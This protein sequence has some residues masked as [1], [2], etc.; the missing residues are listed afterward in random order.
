MNKWLTR[1][2]L[3]VIAVVLV[4]MPIRSHI[5][6]TD[7]VPGSFL[8]LGD[9]R[10][11][12]PE[13]TCDD[14]PC[15]GHEGAWSPTVRDRAIE[16]EVAR[17]LDHL[18]SKGQ[19]TM[20]RSLK[21]MGRYEDYIDAALAARHL[22]SSLRYLPLVEA[23]YDHLAVSPAGAAGLWQ[24]MPATAR[25]LGLEVNTLVDQRFDE[26]AA[27][28]AALDYLAALQSRFQSWLLALAAYNAGPTRLEGAIR[29]HGEGRS[30][31]DGLFWHI[32]D[33]LPEETRD[34][35]PKFLAS[36]RLAGH[37]AAV[38]Q[39]A[40]RDPPERF[41][42][43]WIEGAASA[44]VL[45]GAA[46][47]A[48]DEFMT[49]NPH[50]RIGLTP[51]DGSTRLRVP[52]GADEMFLVHFARIPVGGRSTLREHTVAPGETLTRI[53]QWHG[54]SLDALRTVNPDVEPRRMQV[55]TVLVI[56]RGAGS[57]V[58]GYRIEA[59]PSANLSYTRIAGI[60]P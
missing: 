43:V 34:F 31:D 5:P 13:P 55:G 32:R 4:M 7:S 44:D 30:L 52:F 29:R 56:P 14:R 21:R 47:I 36:V 59:A 23:G 57:S 22:P 39:A 17:W 45:A 12:R 40:E 20:R 50:L 9:D 26:H 3:A 1:S 11:A 54:V 49:L 41:D 51:A 25:S 46:G 58:G 10:M 60:M 15:I 2:V 37:L 42:V 24:L 16:E 38:G 18:E 8:R 53:A 19:G 6:D 33:R 35:V 28:E 27:T 48:E